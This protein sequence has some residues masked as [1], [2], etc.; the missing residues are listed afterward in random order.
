MQ[1]REFYPS[2]IRVDRTKEGSGTSDA[3][4]QSRDA[5]RDLTI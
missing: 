3:D 5:C 1:S 4:P 2:E